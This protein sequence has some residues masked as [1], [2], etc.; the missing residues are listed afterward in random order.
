VLQGYFA[1]RMAMYIK[2]TTSKGSVYT[3]H[4]EGTREYWMKE[5]AD[6]QIHPVV[7]GLHISKKRLK[8]LIKEYPSSLLDK[9]YC[10]DEGFEREFFDDAKREQADCLFEAEETV[11][12]FIVKR[13]SG[14]HG[15]G[16]S[17]RVVRIEKGE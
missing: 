11:I 13:E 17:S 6:G 15:M 10:F 14:R 12:F 9:T 1:E 7:E 2:Y 5:D 16:C 3:H 4:Y 8:E